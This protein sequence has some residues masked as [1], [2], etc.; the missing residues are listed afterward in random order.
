MISPSARSGNRGTVSIVP[1]GVGPEDCPTMD[2][3]EPEILELRRAEQIEREK[4]CTKMEET[5]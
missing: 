2:W 5:V 1:E 3:T 4:L